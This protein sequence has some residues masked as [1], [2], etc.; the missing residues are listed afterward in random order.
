VIWGA[1][2]SAPFL[3]PGSSKE[4]IEQTPRKNS[5]SKHRLISA[6]PQPQNNHCAFNL[7]APFV[8]TKK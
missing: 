5:L 1:T 6:K 7:I 8:E 3:L 4:F 2:A